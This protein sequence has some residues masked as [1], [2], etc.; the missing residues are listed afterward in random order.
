MNNA[1]QIRVIVADDH[2][3]FR[4]GFIQTLESNNSVRVIAEA[5]SGNQ[6]IDSVKNTDAEIISLDLSMPEKSG[7]DLIKIIKEIAPR[8]NILVVSMHDEM[9]LIKL[10]IKNGAAGFL[11]KNASPEDV[12]TAIHT[13]NKGGKYLP[14]DIAEKIAFS[15]STNQDN[16]ALTLREIEILRMIAQ[17]GL[18]LVEIAKRL[19][20]SPK[21]V[22]SHKTNIMTKL[23]VESNLD[24]LREASKIL[25]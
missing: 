18:S 16:Q 12:H 6:V 17:E 24:L 19:N 20:L 5:A 22:T 2:A 8:L 1:N 21:T 10:A 11:T 15:N 13:I 25:Q 7:I 23:G 4:A 3:L 14:H 9:S